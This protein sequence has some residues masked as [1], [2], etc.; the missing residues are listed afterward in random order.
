MHASRSTMCRVGVRLPGKGSTLAHECHLHLSAAPPAQLQL[1]SL[2]RLSAHEGVTRS[3]MRTGNRRLHD[4][5][6][7]RAAYHSEGVLCRV[8]GFRHLAREPAQY[9][10]TLP[11]PRYCG[12]A[13]LV[14][15]AMYAVANGYSNGYWGWGGEDDD[16]CLRLM[17]QVHA[18]PAYRRM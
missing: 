13:L 10:F 9:D 1:T 4:I 3:V 11:M 17:R 6:A 15:A 8:H 18:F 12:G 2:Q 16:F 5:V 14:T 7:Q